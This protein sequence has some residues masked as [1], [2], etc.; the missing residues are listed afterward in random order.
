[1]SP[2]HWVTRWVFKSPPNQYSQHS[3]RSAPWQP[4]H[5]GTPRS[6]QEAEAQTSSFISLKSVPCYVWLINLDIHSH[7]PLGASQALCLHLWVVLHGDNLWCVRTHC[8]ARTAGLLRWVI[9]ISEINQ[10]DTPD[11]G[12]QRTGDIRRYQHGSASGQILQKPGR[13]LLQLFWE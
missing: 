6:D 11:G 3:V 7:C 8:R 1:M 4:G 2:H 9:H 12:Q 13:K 5:R 10:I